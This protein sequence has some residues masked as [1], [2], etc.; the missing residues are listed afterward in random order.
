MDLKRYCLIELLIR[1]QVWF[2][3]LCLNLIPWR[4]TSSG[5]EWQA[6]MSTIEHQ[7]VVLVARRDTER[8]KRTTAD[9]MTVR[10]P[11]YQKATRL[12]MFV[13][14]RAHLSIHCENLKRSIARYAEHKKNNMDIRALR[15]GVC[16]QMRLL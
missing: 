15:D 4:K 1:L 13:L 8:A 12:K 16:C 10:L 11:C 5:R 6:A 3:E 7:V 9:I 14:S 2:L